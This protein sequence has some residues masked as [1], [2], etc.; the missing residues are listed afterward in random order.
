MWFDKKEHDSLN[1]VRYP[2]MDD[3]SLYSHACVTWSCTSNSKIDAKVYVISNKQF[4]RCIAQLVVQST[5]Q[6][7]AESGTQCGLP[8]YESLWTSAAVILCHTKWIRF[9]I[10]LCDISTILTQIINFLAYL[11]YVD[12]ETIMV[13]AEQVEISICKKGWFAI[14]DKKK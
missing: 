14:L 3:I 10:M 13:S 2:L 11:F 8:G 6:S 4:C 12:W 9:Q 1:N 7:I 5:A